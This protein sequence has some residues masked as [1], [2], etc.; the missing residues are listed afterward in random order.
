VIFQVLENSVEAVQ[1]APE[2]KNRMAVKVV[3][4]EEGERV[5]ISISD[6]GDG[7]RKKNLALI[8]EP[9][10]TTRPGH[11]GLGLTSVK[12]IMDDH[13]GTVRVES[14]LK[15]GTTV[16]LLFPKDRRRRIRRELLFTQDSLKPVELDRK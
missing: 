6:K 13:G 5:G 7:I 1:G 3:L 2:G 12:R 16:S 11:I 15:Q 14:R 4:F 10:F 9:F 8:F